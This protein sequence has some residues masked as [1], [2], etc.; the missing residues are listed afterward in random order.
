MK[1]NLKHIHLT[2]DITSIYMFFNTKKPKKHSCAVIVRM[3]CLLPFALCFL[4]FM[5]SCISPYKPNIS[6]YENVFVVDGELTNLDGPYTV[7]LS[8]SY[9][10]DESSGD[11]VTGALVKIIDNT[12]LE[13]ELQEASDGVYT[14]VDS[15]FQGVI[16]NSYK[17]HIEV[18]DEVYESD[19]ETLREPIEIDSIYWEYDSDK[20]GIQLLLDTH[21][22][23][24]STHYYMWQYEETWKFRVPIDITDHPEWKECYDYS[25]S[26]NL[27]IATSS[28]RTED[29]IEGHKIKFIDEN[30]NRLYIRYSILVRQMALSDE[31][32]Q[33]FKDLVTLN[34]NQGTLFDPIP[35]SLVGNMQ[36]LTNEDEPVLGYFLV[37]GASEKR[38]FIDN[39]ELPNEYNPTD[40]FDDCNTILLE[41]P[42]EYVSN[43]R[44]YDPADSI[45]SLGYSIIEE[46]LETILGG[47]TVIQLT[48]AKAPCYNCTLNG[49]NE[50]PDFWIEKDDD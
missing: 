24:N 26:S 30:T 20:D 49:D 29:I 17:L 19:F 10:F 1:T 47:D 34:V 2:N 33:V 28:Q 27:D 36:N 8:R 23:N 32:Y 4:L 6:K 35:S 45:M 12:G 5:Y 9:E 15:T 21:D 3:I 25:T 7:T 43:V 48:F 42:Y 40:G 14:T 18:D 13:V 38:I 41:V 39:S 31:A 11:A 46:Y 22:P 50:V 44:A 37:A 16:G